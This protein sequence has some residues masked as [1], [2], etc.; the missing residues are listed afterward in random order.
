M[1]TSTGA[2]QAAARF[3]ER[4]L[5][6]RDTRVRMLEAG[7]GPPL[8]YLHDSGDL[9]G[10]TPL[11]SGLAGRYAVRRPDH[12]GFNASEDGTD[13]D[14]VHD[15]AFFYLDLLDEIGA[16]RAVVIGT[17]LGGWLAADLATIDPGRVAVLVLAGAFGIRAGEPV[18]DVFLRSPAELAELTYHSGPARSAALRQAA[19]LAEDADRFAR[20]LRNRAATAHL[21]WN[22]YLHDPKLPRRLHRI[23]APTLI[24]WGAQDRILP[25][26]HARRW[27]A[28][29]PGA[30]VEI[31]DQ[32]GHCPFDE[33][34]GASLRALA[35]LLEEG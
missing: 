25:A 18:P 22:P 33:Q 35:T 24:V 13:I 30:R 29:L 23:T 31:I 10:W 26:G 2:S 28:L 16:E 5:T 34:P 1:M 3:A 27:A 9:G 6:V 21:G 19:Q 15:L 4:D 8:L 17:G 32:A 12:P 14:S 7:S 11:L 20:Y